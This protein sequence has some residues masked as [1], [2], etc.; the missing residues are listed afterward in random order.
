M[1]KPHYITYT[2]AD[3]FCCCT[4]LPE[5]R[6]VGKLADA[7]AL[8]SDAGSAL[9]SDSQ[10]EPAILKKLGKKTKPFNSPMICTK[11]NMPKQYFTTKT[12]G[13]KAIGAMP[14]SVDR[15]P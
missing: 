3:T 11:A 12:K 9:D 14:T 2:C 1:S 13:L 5:P 15:E 10:R 6:A 4:S 7:G 8:I